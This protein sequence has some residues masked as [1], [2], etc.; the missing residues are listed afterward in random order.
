MINRNIKID[1]STGW[2]SNDPT[3]K[4]LE[5]KNTKQLFGLVIGKQGLKQ[6]LIKFILD[7]GILISK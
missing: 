4:E 6:V 7:N 3:K 1:C 5:K 2:T